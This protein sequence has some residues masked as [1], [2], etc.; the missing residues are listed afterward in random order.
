MSGY[1]MASEYID[2]KAWPRLASFPAGPPAAK[3]EHGRVY[4][5]TGLEPS[6]A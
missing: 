2:V 4:G 3:L 5:M 1:I 6:R